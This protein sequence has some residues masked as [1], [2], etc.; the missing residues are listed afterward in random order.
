[1]CSERLSSTAGFFAFVFGECAL[2]CLGGEVWVMLAGEW[3]LWIWINFPMF[4]QCQDCPGWKKLPRN[5]KCAA[6]T[7][8][9]RSKAICF[10]MLIIFPTWKATI[11]KPCKPHIKTH[12]H[13]VHNLLY[14]WQNCIPKMMT[15][16]SYFVSQYIVK[17]IWC[18]KFEKCKKYEKLGTHFLKIF[19]WRL[20]ACSIGLW[21]TKWKRLEFDT[22]KSDGFF[23]YW[24]KSRC[25]EAL[26]QWGTDDLD[27]YE[28]SPEMRQLSEVKT[29]AIASDATELIQDEDVKQSIECFGGLGGWCFRR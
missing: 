15:C 3:W 17:I 13:L 19:V 2:T 5:V 20:V 23:E 18:P 22:P 4:S 28:V 16:A 25:C 12:L 7:I 21:P 26:L 10:P 9:V 1:M 14:R 29:G 8:Y 6:F 24:P 27:G 11:M